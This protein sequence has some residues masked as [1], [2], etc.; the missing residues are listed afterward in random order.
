[1]QPGDQV[2]HYEILSAIGSGGMGEVWKARDTKLR[3][4]VAIKAL[5]PELAQD[6]DR[7]ARLEREATSLAAVNHPNI[8]AIHGLEEHA[9]T[10][11][12]VLELVE[13]S[14]LAD[15]L[16]KGPMPLEQALKIALQIA[17]ALEAAHERGV[18]HRDLKPANVMVTRDGRVKVLDFGLAKTLQSSAGDAISH[19]TMRADAGGIMG[20]APYLSPEQARGESAGRQTDI[21]SFGVVLYEMLTGDSPF[22]GGTTPATLGRV[23]EAQPNY[24]LIPAQTPANVRRL[25]KRCLEK[26]QRRRVQHIGDVRIE[27]EDALAAPKGE[28]ASGSTS[29]A[30]RNRGIRY[31]AGVL[32]VAASAAIGGLAVWSIAD[33]SASDTGSGV[34]RLSIASLGAPTFQPFGTRH[35]AI[36]DDGSRVA[37]A[38]LSGLSIR[39]LR[40]QEAITVDVA[41]WN[42]FFS[43]DGEWLGFFSPSG[44]RKV[45]SAGGTPLLIAAT[46]ERSMGATWGNDGTIVF[47]TTSGLY[48]VADNGGTAPRLLAKPDPER[49]ERLYAW[50][51]LMPGGRS[52]L[53]TVVSEGSIDTAEIAWL[54]LETLERGTVLTGGTAPRVTSTG[55]L[56]YAAGEALTAIA[57]DGAAR[58]ARG[59][60]MALGGAAIA[61]T[62][63]NG[64]AEFA[65]S[66]T[67]TLVFMAPNAPAGRASRTLSWLD[68]QGNE[69]PLALGPGLYGYPRI[70]PDGTRI[71]LDVTGDNRDIWI[72][73]LRRASLTRLTSGPGED[74]LPVWSPDGSRMFFSSD[75]AGNFDIYSQAADGSTEA[76]VE[77]AAP[78]FHGSNSFTPDGAQLVVYEEFRDL[79]VLDLARGELKPLL[80]RESDDRLGEVSPDGRWIAYESDESGE[81]IE[82]F[83][84]PFPDVMARREKVSIDGGRYPRWGSLT[85]GE[86]YYVDLDGAM[87][88]AAIEL[89]PSLR[90]GSVSKL[91]DLE[92]PPRTV[93]GRPY[94]V[95]P[96]DGRFLVTKPVPQTAGGTAEISVVLN[97]FDELKDQV[98]RE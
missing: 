16:R 8:A 19:L 37:Y 69:E 46:T 24:A 45:P 53:F 75:R 20:T 23:L 72:W 50:P 51:Q 73:D 83:L 49:N 81:Q 35:L 38:S 17:E 32:A 11:F 21:W 40:E 3:R 91:F 34:V 67:G 39:R 64:A 27:I 36:S 44:Y 47:A 92:M 15:R 41:A 80:H 7:L 94:D 77:L 52:V 59:E 86:L 63:D 85:S 76:R 68:R 61:T 98:P 84:R 65:I 42:P 90:V 58:E 30:A 29:P 6:S 14:T 70:S 87:M 48:Q 13:G 56:V 60:P 4:E 22:E 12:L 9:G 95:S 43:P 18:I 26:D 10:R 71:A 79:S 66:A 55:H 5:P 97:W 96:L 88:A 54:D 82:I 62:P 28:T 1:M 78:E 93:S 31:T 74:M 57:F 33:R 89:S 2:A 25:L